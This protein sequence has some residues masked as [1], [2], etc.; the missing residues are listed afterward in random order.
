MPAINCIVS[1]NADAVHDYF[2]L[3]VVSD[4]GV[5]A[6]DLALRWPEKVRAAVLVGTNHCVDEQAVHAEHPDFVGSR[7]VDFLLRHG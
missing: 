2:R 1:P 4:G 3:Q 5:L 6:L 7:I